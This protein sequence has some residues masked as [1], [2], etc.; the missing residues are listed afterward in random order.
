LSFESTK[1]TNKDLTYLCIASFVCCYCY[2]TIQERQFPQK[3]P[4]S[5]FK[6]KTRPL[7]LDISILESIEDQVSSF[8]SRPS[9]DFL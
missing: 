7:K 4:L 6:I 8:E 5:V 9:Q 2:V 3:T 1:H